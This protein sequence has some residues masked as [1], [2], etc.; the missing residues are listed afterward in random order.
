MQDRPTDRP[1][2]LPVKTPFPTSPY[3]PADR[4]VRSPRDSGQ[5]VPDYGLGT[6][7]PLG[8][9]RIP[10][11]PF[12]PRQQSQQTRG[13]GIPRH[14]RP[15]GLVR[16]VTPFLSI[17]YGTG[18]DRANGLH[19]GEPVSVQAQVSPYRSKSF[20]FKGLKASSHYHVLGTKSPGQP[21]QTVSDTGAVKPSLYAS[22][23]ILGG[24]RGNGNGWER[25]ANGRGARGKDQSPGYRLPRSQAPPSTGLRAS[26]LRAL[27]W[28]G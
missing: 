15:A 27:D 7:S 10:C 17:T 2:S 11:D 12:W 13:A 9:P 19:K 6:W 14:P 28:A 22:G 4:V 3:I 5:I 18:R 16:D 23:V 25:R 1:N 8:V 26:G 24:A 20:R 21:V